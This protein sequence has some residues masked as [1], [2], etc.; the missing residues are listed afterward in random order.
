MSVAK[1]GV[2][3]AKNN[4]VSRILRG[5]FIGLEELKDPNQLDVLSTIKFEICPLMSDIC[6]LKRF[7]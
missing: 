3:T 5:V 7:P 2:R 4:S 1:H 6:P